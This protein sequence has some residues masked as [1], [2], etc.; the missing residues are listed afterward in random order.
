MKT[1]PRK[2]RRRKFTELL[3]GPTGSAV[4][5]ILV[6]LLLVK[7]VVYKSGGKQANIEVIMMDP[8]TAD[9]EELKKELEELKEIQVVDALTPPDISIDTESLEEEIQDFDNPDPNVDFEALDVMDDIQS[10]LVMRGLYQGRSE[11]G[12]R[13]ALKKHARKW[14]QY[15]EAAV[16][17]ALQWLKAN[18]NE[19][20]SWDNDNQAAMTGLG[21]LTFLAHGETPTSEE[22]GLTVE[23]AIRW[24]VENQEESG[25]WPMTGSHHVYG[26]GIAAYSVAEA[27]G[28]TQIPTLRT[29]MERAIQVI[30][31]G[32]QPGGGW[33]YDYAKDPRRDTSVSGWQIQALKA[34][35]IADPALPGVKQALRKA[36]V[37]L[38]RAQA[39]SGRFDYA[40]SR[41]DGSIGMT[42]VG[43]LCLQ[44]LGEANSEACRKGTEYLAEYKIKL[45]WDDPGEWGLY[46]WY[47]ITQA[48]FH[49]GKDWKNWNNRFAKVFTE[50][51]NS[52]GSWTGPG[53]EEG[54]GKVYGTTL[55]A[56]TLQVYY[57]LLPTYQTKAVEAEEV[58]EEEEED[59]IEVI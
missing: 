17:R 18:Q 16:I 19:D 24:L 40:V 21:L 41:G 37:D 12:R 30:V 15:T 20:G 49:Q 5:H 39:G 36:V 44:L 6:I 48:K 58:E 10:P 29:A 38:K 33:N 56:L 47:Y 9:L 35:Y 53:N 50:A 8:E 51:Q 26:Q 45:D 59:L 52:D 57:R 13:D 28:L 43:V 32:Q 55:A 4:I 25:D 22:F 1:P 7:L 34:A 3:L 46:G 54:K 14:G 27:Y 11:G 23:N 42:G 31:S 2:Q